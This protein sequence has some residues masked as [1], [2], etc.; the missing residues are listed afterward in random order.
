MEQLYKGYPDG[1]DYAFSCFELNGFGFQ[2]MGAAPPGTLAIAFLARVQDW[3]NAKTMAD[4]SRPDP[5]ENEVTT[6]LRKHVPESKTV[7]CD[8]YLGRRYL[9]IHFTEWELIP[10]VLN[11]ILQHGQWQ[12]ATHNKLRVRTDVVQL[13]GDAMVTGRL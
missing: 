13:S 3:K 4:V 12:L 9:K 10:A 7:T 8:D 11:A 6:Y 5:E 2:A 1:L